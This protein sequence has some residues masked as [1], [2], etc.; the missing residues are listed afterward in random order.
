MEQTEN[1][2]KDIDVKRVVVKVGSRV[3]TASDGQLNKE[4]VAALVHEIAGLCGSG[5]EVALVS[6]G[7]VNL[8]RSVRQL[9]KFRIL[10]ATP[11]MRVDLL[12]EQVLAA[13]GQPRLLAFYG[14]E[15][16]RY[17][18]A[19][20]QL[21]TT[22]RDFADRDPYMYLRAVTMSLLSV[23]VVPIFNEND[24]LSPEELD[25]SDNDQ[26]A[27]MVAAMLV[28]DKL[29]ILTNVDGVYDRSP[30]DPAAKLIR[31]LDNPSQAFDSIDSS[32]V[33]GKGGMKSKLMAASLITQL[34]IPVH[35]ANGTIE[36]ILPK[37]IAGEDIGTVCPAQGS[38]E[39]TVKSWLKTAAASKGRVVVST[40]L[41]EVLRQRRRAASVLLFGVERVEGDFEAGD[42]VDVV[43]DDGVLLGRGQVK[44]GS[45]ELDEEARRFRQ[46]TGEERGSDEFRKGGGRIAIHYDYFVFSDGRA[47]RQM[48]TSVPRTV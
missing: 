32:Q 27:Y 6:S 5:L 28:A 41:A 35:I 29:I 33:S 39:N 17:D 31:R 40:T 8:G 30:S 45:K 14:Q 9:K 47:R 2:K 46:A 34:G 16:E 12:K 19:C 26:L 43:D 15:F 44:F 38:R 37:I 7:A 13:V 42:A 48:A 11:T 18:L 10:G 36:H 25:F 21:L 1:S 24:V 23:G 4:R 20:A 3:L 22:R